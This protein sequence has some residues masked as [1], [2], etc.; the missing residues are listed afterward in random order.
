MRFSVLQSVLQSNVSFTLERE[1]SACTADKWK[2]L[3]STILYLD[4]C[5]LLSI[6]TDCV[7][8]SRTVGNRHQSLG[9]RAEPK[10]HTI[11]LLICGRENNPSCWWW[12]GSSSPQAALL[13]VLCHPRSQSFPMDRK[14]RSRPPSWG[15][16]PNER[17]FLSIRFGFDF[18]F[19]N[20]TIHW[21]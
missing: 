12:W 20:L 21:P 10:L 8:P 14:R 18:F 2:A 6:W 1:P 11:K 4:N 7:K 15:L 19:N 5:T 9:Y 13:A 3:P 16:L 17:W